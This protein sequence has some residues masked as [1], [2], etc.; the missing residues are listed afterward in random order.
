MINYKQQQPKRSSSGGS[1]NGSPGSDNGAPARL[2][3]FISS[4]PPERTVVV[5]YVVALR[6]LH[7]M[8]LLGEPTSRKR[9]LFTASCSLQSRRLNTLIKAV[10]SCISTGVRGQLD[11]RA[12]AGQRRD[13]PRTGPFLHRLACICILCLTGSVS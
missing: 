2:S 4:P 9:Q 13:Q 1:S 5:H 7:V 8:H 10:M 12:A 6:S 11:Q 3:K